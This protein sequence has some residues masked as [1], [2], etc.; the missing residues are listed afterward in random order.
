MPLTAP[1]AA[2]IAFIKAELRTSS[3][4]KMIKMATLLNLSVAHAVFAKFANKQMLR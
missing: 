3:G 2:V 4:M 1:A